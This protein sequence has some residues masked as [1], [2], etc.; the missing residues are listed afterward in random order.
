M[1]K[2]SKLGKNPAAD[3]VT[4]RSHADR[5]SE[6]RQRLLDA[7]IESLIELGYSRTT[8]T[9][10]CNRAGLSRGAQLHHFPTKALLVIASVKHLG[11]EQQRV[12]VE[13]AKQIIG[14]KDLVDAGLELL[15]SCSFGPFN[16]AIMELRVAA[17]TDA[18]LRE[19][20]I[21]LERDI[22]SDIASGWRQLS[23]FTEQREATIEEVEMP[24][25]LKPLYQIG[26]NLIRGMTLMQ[27]L[28]PNDESRR[29]LF[30]TWKAL[31]TLALN[32]PEKWMPTLSDHETTES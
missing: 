26:L 13:Q 12:I 19:A 23:N 1:S 9:E 2:F 4:R 7:T 22:E 15:W 14:S 21:E 17:R 27:G 25:H 10:V 20:V 6:T 8:T 11:S 3:T 29:A 28:T 30:D 32:E 31:V 5:S 18:D 16:D 24:P